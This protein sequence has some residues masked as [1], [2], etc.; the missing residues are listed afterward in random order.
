MGIACTES[1]KDIGEYIHNR[2]NSKSLRLIEN[3]VNFC[4]DCREDLLLFIKITVVLKRDNKI[5]EIRSIIGKYYDEL[6]ECA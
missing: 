1:K 6:K 2:L 3:H 4:N 5:L